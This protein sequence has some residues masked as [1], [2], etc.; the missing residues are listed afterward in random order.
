MEDTFWTGE[1][2]G[3]HISEDPVGKFPVDMWGQRL[4]TAE[5]R[6]NR[7]GL[8]H[9]LLVDLINPWSPTLGMC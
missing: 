8:P 5:K 7:K 2:G 6:K 3:I 9:F 4:R 1:F